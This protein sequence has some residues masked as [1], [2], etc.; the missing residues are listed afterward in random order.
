MLV[1]E[2]VSRRYDDGTIA[3]NNVSL[4]IPQGEF[5][6]LL[7][8]SGA[9]KSTLMNMIN[10]M[11]EPTSG[12]VSFDDEVITRSNLR[13][14]QRQVGMIHQQLHLIPRL[15]V[16]HNVLSGLLPER[17]FWRSFI[18]SF[19]NE[20]SKKITTAS[21]GRTLGCF[22]GCCFTMGTG[23]DQTQYAQSCFTGQVA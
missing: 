18:K 4:Q 8:P 7:G 17:G 9:G 23:Q 22:L 11:V 19:P 10:G 20:E 16:L 14:F 5:C 6:V 21:S 12:K 15:S 3:V 13:Q 2:S 1:F